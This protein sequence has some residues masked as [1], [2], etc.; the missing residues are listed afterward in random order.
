MLTI[1]NNNFNIP[2]I[3]NLSSLNQSDMI[4]KL[5]FKGLDEPDNF[6]KKEINYK[7]LATLISQEIP[8]KKIT[9]IYED[10]LDDPDQSFLDKIKTKKEKINRKIQHII[11]PESA[12]ENILYGFT[13]S[14][15]FLVPDALKIERDDE[16][17]DL[18]YSTT[19]SIINILEDVDNYSNFF[20]SIDKYFQHMEKLSYTKNSLLPIVMSVVP[21]NNYVKLYYDMK[22]EK[23]K[24]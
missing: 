18:P 24:N 7:R 15:G 21:Y 9:D 1:I 6:S 16:S 12:D 20:D 5:N 2:K 4:D 22:L 3:S 11:S 19:Q 8:M 17:Y 23:Q 10:M 14:I 13:Q